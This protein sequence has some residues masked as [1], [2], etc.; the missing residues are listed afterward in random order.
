MKRNRMLVYS[1]VALALLFAGNTLAREKRLKKSDLPAAV[2]KTADEQSEGATV[3]GYSSEV[4]GGRLQYEVEI[5]VKGH[6]RDVIIAPD[7]SILTVEEQ[8]D[9]DALPAAVREGLHKKAG[10]GTITKVESIT[11]LGKLVAYEA[12]VRTGSK[13]SEIQIGP[14]GKPLVHKE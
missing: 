12:Q 5:V 2:Q 9:L 4:D 14:D 11:K 10:T 6:S 1:V 8:V 3:R 7:G 13:R